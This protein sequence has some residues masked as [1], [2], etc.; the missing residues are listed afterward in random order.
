MPKRILI[1]GANGMLGREITDI[2][3]KNKKYNVFGIIRSR[4][5]KNPKV[6]F[7]IADL[8]DIK[9]LKKIVSSVKPNII[10]HSAAI[11]NLDLCEQNK[12]EADLLHIKATEILASYKENKTK[13]VYISTD[14]VFNGKTGAYKESDRP[15]P[16]N[17]YAQSKLMGEKTAM[18]IN[19]NS[20]VIRTNIYGFHVPPGNSLV[21][22]A[23]ENF[24]SKK[25]INGFTDVFFNPVYT[26]QLAKIIKYIL[27]KNDIK[28]I[29]NIGSEESMNKYEFLKS[30][31]SRFEAQTLIKPVLVNTSDLKTIRPKNTILDIN[32]LK[33]IL[34][35]KTLKISKGL[36]EL[37]KDY[38]KEI[39]KSK[40]EKN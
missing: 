17:Y 21:E 39:K 3:S 36:S 23:L 12:R 6:C 8:R 11:V 25:S 35:G 32:K 20:L 37:K 13:F 1:T 34:G 40:Y 38:L 15:D 14:S 19:K 33:K 28:G 18:A 29:L 7:I 24:T 4:K 16:L 31:A 22:W 26:R 5:P 10:I 9:S 2:F 27:E 30:L